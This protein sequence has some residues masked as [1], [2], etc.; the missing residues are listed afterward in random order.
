M[1]TEYKIIGK[2]SREAF[3]IHLPFVLLRMN[4]RKV[5]YKYKERIRKVFMSPDH[6]IACS[7]GFAEVA[8]QKT[9][10]G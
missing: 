2:Q 9:K 3:P 4:I 8:V 7:R 6:T 5:V 10:D 1:C